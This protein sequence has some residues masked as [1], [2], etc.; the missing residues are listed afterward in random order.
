MNDLI[1][2][3]IGQQRNSASP[4]RGPRLRPRDAIMDSRVPLLTKLSIIIT[5]KCNITCRHCLPDCAPA[6]NKT[7]TWPVLQNIIQAAAEIPSLR[8][9]CFTGG[10]PFMFPGLLGDSVALTHRLGMEST[11]MS[12]AFWATSVGRA[13]D[14]LAAV[15]G[16]TRIGVSTDSFH[17]E[18]ISIDRV[19]NAI[20][21]AHELQ[22]D[23]A[24]RVCHLNDPDAEIEAVRQQLA[25]ISGLYELEHQ[26]VQPLGRAESEIAY[27]TIFSY[28]TVLACCRSADVQA[29][30][31]SGSLTA[32][33]GAT[34]DWP[35][36]HPLDY[37]NPAVLGLAKVF[38]NVEASFIL[39]AVRLWG[40]AGL[41][42]LAQRQA[43]AEGASLADPGIRNIC[44]L[45][46]FVVAD[47]Q[48]AAWL[49]R[50]VE[51]PEVRREIALARLTDL[52]EAGAVELLE[53]S[54]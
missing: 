5:D 30:N 2:L 28:D 27:D 23:C 37:G 21:A 52:G 20:L 19:R 34:G 54:R 16:L 7:L 50:A 1:Q 46:H 35:P 39:H 32:C 13:R 24:V 29:V 14:T 10:E 49:R 43:E 47:E 6:K 3:R 26:P 15:P 4:V 22:I 31:P 18:F 11:V 42:Q 53:Q 51:Q 8:T 48:R 45:C 41:L 40:P 33:C 44:E 9:L 12:N 38:E 36:G 17:Q 25:D